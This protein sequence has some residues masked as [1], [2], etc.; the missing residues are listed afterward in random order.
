MR[1]GRGN[2]SIIGAFVARLMPTNQ[3]IVDLRGRKKACGDEIAPRKMK[4]TQNLR[5]VDK[6][7]HPDEIGD[8]PLQ[9]MGNDKKQHGY[10]TQKLRR[11][12]N[13]TWPK[14][15]FRDEIV[16]TFES[17]CLCSSRT[18]GFPAC[19]DGA[20]F[21]FWKISSLEPNQTKTKSTCTGNYV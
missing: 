7:R 14:K 12:S 15:P 6:M 11:G 19:I 17:Q 4:W 13:L 10:Q 18:I 2:I 8:Y 20:S 5:E 1:H 21:A 3:M 16:S 9:L